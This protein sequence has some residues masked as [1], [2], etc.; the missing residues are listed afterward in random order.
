MV[1][2]TGVIWKMQYDLHTANNNSTSATLLPTHRC[3]SLEA[4][5]SE[6]LRLLLTHRIIVKVAVFPHLGRGNLD[7]RVTKS[8]Q[9]M[10]VIE[11]MMNTMDGGFWHGK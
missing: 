7:A 3:W 6:E 2:S 5:E 11:C 8:T 1:L 4:H 10:I 9:T